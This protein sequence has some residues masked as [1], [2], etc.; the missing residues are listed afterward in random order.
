MSITLPPSIALYFA[1]DSSDTDS[2]AVLFAN[3]AVVFDEGHNYNGIGAIAQWKAATAKKYD[4]TSVPFA[5]EAMADKFIVTSRVTGNFPGSPVDL[6][7][8]FEL[9]EDKITSLR[10]T[11]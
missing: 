10:I 1:A 4:H 2:V 6:R 11:L 5:C 3:T 7:Y 9:A 8:F